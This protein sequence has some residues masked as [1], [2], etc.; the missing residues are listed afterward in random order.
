MDK[1][2]R[3]GRMQV[4]MVRQMIWEHIEKGLECCHCGEYV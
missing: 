4:Q 3:I 1:L 2:K